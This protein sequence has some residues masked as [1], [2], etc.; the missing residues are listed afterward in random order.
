MLWDESSQICGWK[1]WTMSEEEG[2]DL[3]FDDPNELTLKVI[4]K[5]NKDL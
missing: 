3:D 1:V 4:F 2:S 5:L